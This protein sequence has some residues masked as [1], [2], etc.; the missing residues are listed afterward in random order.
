MVSSPAATGSAEVQVRPL[1][2]LD[3]Q[4]VAELVT[5]PATIAAIRAA[6]S[7]PIDPASVPGRSTARGAGHWL[8]SLPAVSSDG[9]YAGAKLISASSANGCASYLLALF[10]AATM[11]LVALMDAN[12]ITGTRTAATSAIAASLLAPDRPLDVAILG[13]GFEAFKHLSA[14]QQVR[15]FSRIR[16]FSP[17]PS[18]R[19]RFVGRAAAELGLEVEP[20]DSP[21]DAVES[22]ALVVCAARSR[23][24]TPILDGSWLAPGATVISIGSTVPEQREA[25][26]VTF[27]RAR[28]IVADVVDEVVTD[29]GD[30]LDAGAHGVDVAAKTVALADVV[31][32]NVDPRQD[33]ADIV[34]YKSVGSA[35]QDITLA[36]L[37]YQRAVETGTGR[38]QP[39]LIVPV[40]K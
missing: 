25:D 13:S 35:L 14:I 22:A 20:V 3:D 34:L 24:E 33:A 27:D 28:V 5:W 11:E 38:D 10:D 8:R 26:W 1:R 9:G 19:A 31:A 12:T 17:T 16:V 30:G 37:A 36:V 32:G 29:T 2:L 4:Q 40:P 7:A 21:Q 6:Y 18:S 39:A 15:Q 23:N